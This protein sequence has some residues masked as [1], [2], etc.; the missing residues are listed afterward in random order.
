MSQ[1]ATP[2]NWGCG[3]VRRRP[4][5]AG[6]CS[7]LPGPPWVCPPQRSEPL[8]PA[9]SPA[10]V[11]GSRLT[12]VASSE[13]KNRGG[14]ERD[15]W[16]RRQTI[17]AI[18]I[19]GQVVP[20]PDRAVPQHDG[21]RAGELQLPA[22]PAPHSNGAQ[23]A[24]A[25]GG[26]RGVSAAGAFRAAGPAALKRGAPGSGGDAGGRPGWRGQPGTGPGSAG[27]RVSPWG[28]GPWR[29]PAFPSGGGARLGSP[30]CCGSAAPVGSQG[31]A[32]GCDSSEHE[33]GWSAWCAKAPGAPGRLVA[34]PLV[35]YAFIHGTRGAGGGRGIVGRFWRSFH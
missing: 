34:T 18:F 21:G 14:A 15:A 31:A 19:P 4:M 23:P 10:R 12:P 16:Q 33:S 17:A 32:A 13:H 30:G 8:L 22:A 26:R 27:L 11:R 3:A 7:L 28:Q 6:T 29:A 24:R 2:R 1:H 5:V 20:C 35:C 25:A 9:V